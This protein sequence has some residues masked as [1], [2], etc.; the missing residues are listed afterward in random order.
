MRGRCL[1]P[2]NAKYPI[3]GGRG[4][5]ICKRWD[6]YEN[7]LTDMGERPSAKHSLDRINTDGNYEPSN[8]RWATSKE[9]ARNRRIVKLTMNDAIAIREAH[10]DGVAQVT[11]AMYF[12]VTPQ[13]IN[14][15]L[16]G[17]QWQP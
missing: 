3:Y 6:S 8:C 11:L 10:A 5:S 7:F 13:Q 14:H 1:N 9:Q 12:A 15:I 16:K 17:H 4:I 2:N